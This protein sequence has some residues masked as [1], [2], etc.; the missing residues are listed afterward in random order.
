MSD[1]NSQVTSSA[2]PRG[3]TSSLRVPSIVGALMAAMIAA[4]SSTPAAAADDLPGATNTLAVMYAAPS[5]QS[6]ILA[7]LPMNTE[8]AV[9]CLAV[10]PF[11]PPTDVSTQPGA[12]E[13]PVQQA[14]WKVH[15]Q[16]RSGYVAISEITLTATHDGPRL[17]LRQRRPA[18]TDIAQCGPPL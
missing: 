7:V 15:D 3:G 9:V 10:P 2:R 12:G 13:G 8:L 16:T 5:Q 1:R 6:N 18:R 4:G 14:F 17:R 11:G